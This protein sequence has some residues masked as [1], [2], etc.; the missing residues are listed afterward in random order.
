MPHNF[1]SALTVAVLP[2]AILVVLAGVCALLAVLRRR[3]RP[4]LY[5]WIAVI[6]LLGAI[7]ASGVELYGMRTNRGGVGLNTFGGGLVADHFSVYVTIA[8]CVFA[9]LTCLLSD[10]YL[11]RIPTRSGGFF[12]LVLFATAAVSALAGE[13]EMITFFVSLQALLISLGLITAL[14]KVDAR[15][16]EAGFKHLI[17]GG[18]ASAILLYGL[19]ILYGVTGSTDL[20]NVGGATARAPVLTGAGIALVMAG[21]TFAAGVVPLRQWVARAGESVPAVISGFVITMGITGG[22]VAWTRI[23]VSGLGARVHLWTTLTAILIVATALYTAF[24]ALRETRVRRLVAHVASAQA[25]VMLLAVIAFTGYAGGVQ[26]QG[27]TALL[28]AVVVFGLG[29]LATFAVLGMFETAG[30]GDSRDDLRGVAHRSLPSTFL[31]TIALLSLAGFPPLAGFVARLLAFESAV[32]AGF[33]WAVIVVLGASIVMVIPVLRLIAL[34][35]GEAGDEQPFTVA[36]TPLI[37]RLATASCC[38]GVF[39]LTVITAPLLALANGGAGS[40]P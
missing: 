33:G 20:A 21:L 16:A 11:R 25:A 39:F 38:A 34:M 3:E 36:A 9:L 35:Y 27:V 10:S 18:V 13:H 12:A 28:F 1:G 17:E 31:L 24:I 32:D 19:A 30:L 14:L 40:L 15:G 7:A 4:D 26:P 23:G 29:V 5:R 22:V 8:A 2:D 6:A 37:S